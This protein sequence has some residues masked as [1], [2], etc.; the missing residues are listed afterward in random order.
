LGW[1]PSD[2]QGRRREKSLDSWQTPPEKTGSSPINRI[3]KE[4]AKVL[5]KP[6]PSK[7][8]RLKIK[9]GAA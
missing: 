3:R 4:V 5:G 9:E 8:E 1:R 2:N 6:L 7:N